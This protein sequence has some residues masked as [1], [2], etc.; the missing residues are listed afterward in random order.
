MR[1]S[2][3]A[4]NIY[5]QCPLKY[6]FQEIDR[7]K[8]PKSRDMVF[9]T[10]IHSALKFIHQKEQTA[11]S[12]PALPETMAYFGSKWKEEIFGTEFEGQVLFADGKNILEKYYKENAEK[13]FDP[14]ALEMRFEAPV[15]DHTLAGNIDRIDKLEDGSFEII[16]YKTSRRLPSQETVDN[17]LQL[18]IYQIGF[19]KNWPQ[20]NSPIKISLYFLQHGIKLSSSRKPEDIKETQDKILITIEKIQKAI[21]ENDFKPLPGPLC[22]WCEH[23]KICPMF[24]HKFKKMETPE[25]INIQNIIREY[26]AAKEVEQE[27]TKLLAELKDKINQY[28]N[29]Q[30]VER[31]FSD[32]G[33]SIVRGTQQKFGYDW[34]IVSDVLKSAGKWEKVF[35][36]SDAKLKKIL[37]ELK[38]E[39]FRKIEGTKKIEG[40][41]RVLRIEK[42]SEP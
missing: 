42:K 40:E 18:A 36:P 10:I 8:T 6:K 5:N 13:N 3:S 31:I 20:F 34:N 16:D 26:F 24:C 37:P 4:L 30:K 21:Q 2:Y 33:P 22:D 29:A 23:Q 7:I 11:H 14:I 1:T 41:I 15:G 12:F 38:T 35:E 32:D 17:D 27:N 19:L 39:D 9:G 28:C 25:D